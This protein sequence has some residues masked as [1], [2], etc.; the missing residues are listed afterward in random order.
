MTKPS[1]AIGNT[2]GSSSSTPPSSSQVISRAKSNGAELERYY[3]APRSELYRAPA[4]HG[5]QSRK[6]FE[7]FEFAGALQVIEDFFWSDLCDNYLELVKVRAYSAEL[8]PGKR[9][10]L[11]TLKIVFSIQLRLFAPFLPFITE[12]V[13]SW[14]FATSDG[15]EQSIH[16]ASWPTLKELSEVALPNEED[17]YGAAVKVLFEVRRIKSEAK[18]SM[19]TPLRNL[20][21][22]GSAKALSALRSVLGDLYR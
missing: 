14:L 16:T 20:E 13:W 18:V 19:K 17:P 3:R 8:T 2:W 10:A 22:T 12:E 15:E 4:T 5:A 11:A 6:E 7:T 1:L 9:S 21:I